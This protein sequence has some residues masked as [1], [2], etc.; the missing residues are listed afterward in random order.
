MAIKR[1]RAMQGFTLVE[2]MVA[3]VV[4]AVGLLSALS[5]FA[6]SLST[7]Q[8]AQEDL[9]ARQKSKEGL[10]SVFNA[11]DSAQ[12]TF[13]QIKN[14]SQGGIF[15]DGFA[16]IYEPPGADGIANTNDDSNTGGSQ[17]DYIQLPGP[18]GILGT[19]DDV[20]QNLTNFQRQIAITP[21]LIAGTGNENP[22]LRLVTVTVRYIVPQ[23]GQ[24][25]YTVS[26]Y[27][28]KFR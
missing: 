15:V 18:D 6:Y 5:L 23:F 28:S 8:T 21:V 2:V 10:E 3:A 9:I 24:H 25:S 4:M 14:I 11:R 16:P 12:I 1:K 26:A 20:R 27:I 22:N 19:P 13:D 17:I 7:L